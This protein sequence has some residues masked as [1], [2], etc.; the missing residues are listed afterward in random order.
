MTMDYITTAQVDAL[1]GA[2]W[3]GTG[4]PARAVLMANAWL[5]AKPLPEF[6]EVPA[7]VVQAGA[8][9]AREAAAGKLYAAAEVGVLAKSVEA[10]GVSSSKTYAAGARTVTAGEAFAMALLAPYLSAGQIKLVRG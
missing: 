4:D 3:A 10:K 5:S 1:L 6:D 9:I 7:A 2:G 8:E